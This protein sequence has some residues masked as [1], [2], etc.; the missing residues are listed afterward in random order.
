MKGKFLVRSVLLLIVVLFTLEGCQHTAPAEVA[1]KSPETAMSS[2][3]TPTSSPSPVQPL[4]G[5]TPQV[6]SEVPRPSG[7]IEF[8]DVT[9]QAGIHFKHNTG[10]FG[11]KYLPE[12]MGSGVCFIDYDNDG[13]QD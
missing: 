7:A 9:A 2:P 8:V 3:S 13:W 10:A 12:T 6:K 5:P 1:K 4:P 11:K